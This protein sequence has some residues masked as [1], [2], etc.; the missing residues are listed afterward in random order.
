MFES[1][2]LS[3]FSLFLFLRFH[4]RSRSELYVCEHAVTDLPILTAPFF[5][6]VFYY[7]YGAELCYM[8]YFLIS[9]SISSRPAKY[10]LRSVSFPSKRRGSKFYYC[11]D[12]MFY[13]NLLAWS[14]HFRRKY[15]I[16][17]LFSGLLWTRRCVRIPRD[18]HT[19]ISAPVWSIE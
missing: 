4:A 10:L 7:R 11:P 17:K 3:F 1:S 9:L 16:R 14:S 5:H 2:S 19:G 8:H 12:M 15:S 13:C 6:V 18:N